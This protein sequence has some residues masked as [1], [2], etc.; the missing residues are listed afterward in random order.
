MK[1][2]VL[3]FVKGSYYDRSFIVE[4]HITYFPVYSIRVCVNCHALPHQSKTQ[5][6]I[7][8]NNTKKGIGKNS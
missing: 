3:C 5:Y 4:H 6:L 2:C 7:H 1:E 8:L